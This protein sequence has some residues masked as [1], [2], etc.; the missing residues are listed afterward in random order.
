MPLFVGNSLMPGEVAY[1]IRRG[2]HQFL[3]G[4]LVIQ[5]YVW[6]T[7]ACDSSNLYLWFS[8]FISIQL[9][10]RKKTNNHH[11]IS[12]SIFN[13]PEL[14]FGSY[15]GYSSYHLKSFFHFFFILIMFSHISSPTYIQLYP[16][17]TRRFIVNIL[18]IIFRHHELKLSL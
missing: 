9:I 6:W 10:L 17:I 18:I 11:T 7:F 16:L 12:A 4:N 1:S 14:R 13:F 5:S 2:K 15:R 3:N 8:N